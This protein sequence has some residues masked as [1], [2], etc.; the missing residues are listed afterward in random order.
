MNYIPP[1]QP[2]PVSSPLFE[3]LGQKMADD[4]LKLQQV[5]D[6]RGAQYP[7]KRPDVNRGMNGPMG[8]V[9]L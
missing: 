1:P 3:I 6:K 5:K 4:L 9:F 7:A 2:P 8:E